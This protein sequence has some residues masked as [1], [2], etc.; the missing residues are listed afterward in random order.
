MAG[1]SGASND[2]V[3]GYEIL[4]ELGQDRYGIF[5]KA[6][7]R[8]TGTLAIYRCFEAPEGMPPARWKR[9]MQKMSE[10][11]Q[12]QSRI[13]EH[14]GI[15]KVLTFGIDADEFYVFFD[16]VEGRSLRRLLRQEGAQSLDWT[17]DTFTQVA[18]ALDHAARFG[19]CHLDLTYYNIYLRSSDNTVQI[20]YWGLGQLSGR[21]K[22]ATTAPEQLQGSKGDWRTDIYSM[23]ILIYQCL[24]GKRPFGGK[25]P[26]DLQKSILYK[27]PSPIPNQPQSVQDVV[28]K[29]LRKK[30]K[31]RY[32]NC[33]EAI[34]DLR[35]GVSP[36][37]IGAK[38]EA[39]IMLSGMYKISSL[40][41]ALTN[42][43]KRPNEVIEIQAYLDQLS[44]KSKERKEGERV[45][46]TWTRATS[47]TFSLLFKLGIL[48]GIFALCYHA[49]TLP[50][51]YRYATVVKVSGTSE[52]VKGEKATKLSVGDT[53]DGREGGVLRTGSG[54]TLVLDMNGTR[55]KLDPNS[56]LSIHKLGFSKG[57][58]RQFSLKRG[59]MWAKVQP[60][61]GSN[62]K[63]QVAC[64]GVKVSVK[65]TDFTVF[66]TEQG[67]GVGTLEGSVKVESGDSSQMVEQGKKLLALANSAL[68]DPLKLTEEEMQ[69]L[70]K[71]DVDETTGLFAKMSNLYMQMQESTLVPL[72]NGVLS[73]TPLNTEGTGKWF[74]EDVKEVTLARGAMEAIS[75]LMIMGEEGTPHKLTLNTLE[76]LGATAEDRKKWLSFFEKGTLASYKPLPNGGYEITAHA[77]DS[78]HTLIHAKNGKVWAGD[79]EGSLFD[80]PEPKKP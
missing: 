30:P 20:A 57:A 23:G 64:N 51:G 44:A 70:I 71:G 13:P 1:G 17:I 73:F 54:A 40:K 58:V 36:V 14:P 52:W 62:A 6:R 27:R 5:Y 55:I 53:I 10:A 50:S 8:E 26:E 11:H 75:K 25:T 37:D 60:L 42:T 56:A 34:N 31:D 46:A 19:F 28:N 18:N 79:D 61:R 7:H 4:G 32:K 47:S 39:N 35:A 80:S 2:V 59:Q 12:E 24:A 16:Y 41:N 9:A 33:T 66:A 68:P 76:E 3:A 21:R 72:V 22:S 74:F 15:Q 43:F 78:K 67:A 63:F 29:L 69:K 65:G 45:R 77:N 49:A 38:P 48:A